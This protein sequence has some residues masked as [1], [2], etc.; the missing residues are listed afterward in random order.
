MDTVS[1]KKVVISYLITTI[2]IFLVSATTSML[3]FF[4]KG[5]S[6]PNA[7]SLEL[8]AIIQLVVVMVVNFTLHAVFYYGGM[9]SAPIT[10]GLIIGTI[11]GTTYFLVSVFGLNLYDINAEPMQQLATAMGSKVFE[12]CSGGVITA[13]IS[14]SD[15]HKW[16]LLKAF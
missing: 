4:G 6:G 12:Y 16:G 11:L 13:V 1:Q 15:I 2:I 3:G 9:K 5:A 14:V 10:K 8:M 7:M